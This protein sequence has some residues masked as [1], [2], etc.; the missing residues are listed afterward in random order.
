MPS[1]P[2]RVQYLLL[3]FCV[4][5]T[6]FIALE[7]TVIL[8]AFWRVWHFTWFFGGKYRGVILLAGGEGL[9]IMTQSQV[10]LYI[11][12]PLPGPTGI[13]KRTSEEALS[14]HSI[15]QSRVFSRRPCVV[16]PWPVT[17][18]CSK[19]RALFGSFDWMGH[20]FAFKLKLLI[21]FLKC[22]WRSRCLWFWAFQM[23]FYFF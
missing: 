7:N 17:Y 2:T 19:L 11:A 12:L 10:L 15:T 9:I 6:K 13:T 21:R 22:E 3:C 18:W 4:T 23:S 14:T 20:S 8:R 16:V 1:K 5:K